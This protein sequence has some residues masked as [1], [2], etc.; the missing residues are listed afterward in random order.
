MISSQ[1]RWSLVTDASVG[2]TG[3][4]VD[5]VVISALFM[6]CGTCVVPTAVDAADPEAVSFA[7]AGE[8]PVRERALLR[9]TLP[10]RLPVRI[11]VFSVTGR[12]MR[13]LVDRVDEAGTYTVPFEMRG[14]SGRTLGSGLYL[15]HMTA[16]SERRT[17][18]VIAIE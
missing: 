17:V 4:W 2:G 10:S 6:G 5:N 8:N 14:E 1:P 18:R 15:V 13:T 12:K 11:E 3:F 9:Y 7:L 16:G